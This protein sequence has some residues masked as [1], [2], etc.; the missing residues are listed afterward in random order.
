MPWQIGKKG[1]IPAKEK[2]GS[3]ETEWKNWGRDPPWIKNIMQAVTFLHVLVSRKRNIVRRTWSL[4]LSMTRSL[5]ICFTASMTSSPAS[6]STSSADDT[7]QA[8]CFSCCWNVSNWHK[9]LQLQAHVH[10]LCKSISA[11]WEQKQQRVGTGSSFPGSEC[12]TGISDQTLGLGLEM[13]HPGTGRP[14]E[15][16]TPMVSDP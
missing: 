4:V 14:R 3:R 7:K 11:N 12:Y 1:D 2:R 9:E 13:V 5:A 8:D 10:T 15:W 6:F 16:S